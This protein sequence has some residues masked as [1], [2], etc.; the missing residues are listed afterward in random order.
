MNLEELEKSVNL[1]E[2]IQEIENLQRIY[3]Y[4]F[5]LQMWEDIIDLFSDDAES[6]EI[7]DHGLFLGKEGVKKMY[8][9]WIGKGIRSANQ[10]W[11]Q[12]IIT[13]IGG[14]VDISP[15]G[16]TAW[17]RWLAENSS[18]GFD[19]LPPHGKAGC[20]S[21]GFLSLSVGISSPISL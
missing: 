10:P 5:D 17:G 21:Y 8:W 11:I 12:F 16:K 15:D 9:G 4:Y 2:D 1:M 20:T 14:V 7:V 19:E 13:Q 6:V 3:A 18:D